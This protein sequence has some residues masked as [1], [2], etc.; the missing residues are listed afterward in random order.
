MLIIYFVLL[1]IF[2]IRHI[3]IQTTVVADVPEV[4]IIIIV[5]LFVYI[6]GRICIIIVNIDIAFVAI[7]IQFV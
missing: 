6:E 1:F 2:I 5:V 7:A 3:D 4:V